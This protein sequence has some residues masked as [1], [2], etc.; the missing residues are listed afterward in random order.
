MP[1]PS[2]RPNDSG[3]P[4]PFASSTGA[5]RRLTASSGPTN[6]TLHESDHPE[7]LNSTLA[8]DLAARRTDDALL[9][10]G[11]RVEIGRTAVLDFGTATVQGEV[12]A[13]DGES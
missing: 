7:R 9:I 12:I 11:C 4:P 6:G 8:V 13:I 10:H 5:S 3:V 2:A 1:R